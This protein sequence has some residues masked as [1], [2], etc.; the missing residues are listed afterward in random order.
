MNNGANPYGSLIEGSSGMLYGLTSLGGAD[1][2][3]SLFEFDFNLA[4]INVK[5][6]FII[7][8]S[9][10]GYDPR[11]SLIQALDGNLYGFTR[12]GKP[13]SGYRSGG[14]VLFKFDFLAPSWNPITPMHNFDEDLP[15]S[16]NGFEVMGSLIQA[17][18]GKFYGMT[19]LGGI[20]SSGTIFEHDISTNTTTKLHDFNSSTD[21]YKPYGSLMQASDGELYGLAT[22]DSGQAKMFQFDIATNIFTVKANVTG[23]PY[24]TTLIETGVTTTGIKE[25]PLAYSIRIFPNP[26]NDQLNIVFPNDLRIDEIVITD[27]WGK[28]ILMENK[29]IETINI[30][31]LPNGIYLMKA[32]SQNILLYKK[33]IKQ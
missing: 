33:F 4:T 29:N 18:N 25:N 31:S 3:G 2:T 26:A 21:G 24:Y 10:I 1:A 13:G 30:S 16:E 8:P 20:D 17:S 12:Y 19:N 23:T 14:G 22:S 28:T 7:T 15:A 9:G 27:I 6:S 5:Y 11:G 32:K